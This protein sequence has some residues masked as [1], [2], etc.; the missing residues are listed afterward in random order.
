MEFEIE[1]L[2]KQKSNLKL[3]NIDFKSLRKL[4]ATVHKSCN[5]I[6]EALEQQTASLKSAL[7]GGKAQ[8]QKKKKPKKKQGKTIEDDDAFLDAVIAENSIEKERF[9]KIKTEREEKRRNDRNR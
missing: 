6:V 2:S 4:F 1:Q 5:Q 9:D 8:K 7:P 3:Q